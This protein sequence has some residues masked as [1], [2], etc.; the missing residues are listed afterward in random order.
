MTADNLEAMSETNAATAP[1]KN[2]GAIACEKIWDKRS[3]SGIKLGILGSTYEERTQSGSG[4]R[5]HADDNT[6]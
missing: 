1:R 2:V 6:F 4:I 3:I 5:Y